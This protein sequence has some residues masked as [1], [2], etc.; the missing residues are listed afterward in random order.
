MA[1]V[2]CSCFTGMADQ[3]LDALAPGAAELDHE[4][5][6]EQVLERLRRDLVAELEQQGHL[7]RDT[8]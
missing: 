8:F 3:A 6:Y 5:I 1:G 7:L 2:V 4:E